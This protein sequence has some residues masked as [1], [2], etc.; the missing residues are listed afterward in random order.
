MNTTTR[1][2]EAIAIAVH[3]MMQGGF[4][5]GPCIQS[6]PM[7]TQDSKTWEI[8][9]AYEGETGRSET[10]DPPSIVLHVN[11]TTKEV[12]SVELM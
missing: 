12:R 6:R 9:F 8:E 3:D 7:G 5:H 2:S 1:K 11:L 4:K 10:T